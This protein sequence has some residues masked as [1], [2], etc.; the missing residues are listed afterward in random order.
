MKPLSS[1]KPMPPT[2]SVSK[3]QKIGDRPLTSRA[4]P[5][6]RALLCARPARRATLIVRVDGYFDRQEALKAAGLQE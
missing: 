4:Y 6:V 2:T 5:C 3:I 1:A